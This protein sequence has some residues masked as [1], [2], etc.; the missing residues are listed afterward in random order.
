MLQSSQYRSKSIW[1]VSEDGLWDICIGLLLFGIG[2]T[3][4]I[5]QFIWLIGIFM[6]AYFLV[7]MAGKEAITRPRM[8]HFDIQ[9]NQLVNFT[10]VALVDTL[11]LILILGISAMVFVKYDG[12]LPV[13]NLDEYTTMILG[14]ISSILLIQFGF[15]FTSGLR[16]YLY[17]GLV[18]IAFSVTNIMSLPIVPVIYTVGAVFAITGMYLLVRFI[19]NYPKS[20]TRGDVTI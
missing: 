3:T 13:S 19:Y 9:K 18:L 12:L 2:I 10:V 1:L 20:G 6:L 11:I 5:N 14:F 16:F 4:S 17:A 15:L 7:L 8:I